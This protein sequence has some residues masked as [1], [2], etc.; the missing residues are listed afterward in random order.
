[1]RLVPR[2]GYAEILGVRSG[3][4]AEL[5]GLRDGDAVLTIDGHAVDGLTEEDLEA[6]LAG[7]PYQAMDL[8]VVLRNDQGQFEEHALRLLRGR[9]P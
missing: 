3:G 9:A 2:E 8:L 6:R 5:L 1:M 4:P 7:K